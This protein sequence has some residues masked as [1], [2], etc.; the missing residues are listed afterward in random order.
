MTTL[1]DVVSVTQVRRA[2]Q[3]Q[4]EL[5]LPYYLARQ[6]QIDGVILDAPRSWNLL[7]NLASFSADQSPAVIIACPGTATE[8]TRYETSWR[9]VFHIDVWVII[10]GEDYRD[11][12]EAVG[13]YVCAMRNLLL[14]Q[15]VGIGGGVRLMS[16]DYDALS[17]TDARTIG[18]GT[19]SVTVPIDEAVDDSQGPLIPPPAPYVDTPDELVTSAIITVGA[20]ED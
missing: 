3:E 7:P 8:P 4:I 16:E 14:Q 9:F 19:V 17:A 11:T 5:W 2:V 20:K 12:T 15:G 10:R 13:S 6:A 1:G 18:G